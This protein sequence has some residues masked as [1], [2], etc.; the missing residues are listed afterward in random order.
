MVMCLRVMGFFLFDLM[1]C[2]SCM[3]LC[4]VLFV[5]YVVRLCVGHD[6]ATLPVAVTN[7]FLVETNKET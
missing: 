3:V 4:V 2:L 1:L 7:F 6:A 5:L